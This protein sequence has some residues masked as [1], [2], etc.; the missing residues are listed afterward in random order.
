[1]KKKEFRKKRVKNQNMV[2]SKKREVALK[3]KRIQS[4][5]SRFEKYVIPILRSKLIA[6]LL[7][8]LMRF[9]IELFSK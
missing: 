6:E 9:I 3:T 8:L 7:D 5:W 4:I 2:H 1:M